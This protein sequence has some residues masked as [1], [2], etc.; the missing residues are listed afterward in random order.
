MTRPEPP[1][2]DG[3]NAVAIRLPSGGFATIADYL[4]ARFGQAPTEAAITRG[5]V[6]DDEL[7][8]VDLSTPFTPGRTTW[9]YRTPPEEAPVPFGIDIL[10]RDDD[11]IVVDKPHFLATMPRGRH[12][13]ESVVVRLR[14]KTGLE[15]CSPAHR[16]DRLTAGVLVC[17][18]RPEVRGVYQ[19]LFASR[20]VVKTYEA[21]AAASNLEFPQTVRSRIIKERGVLTAAEVP[22]EPNS[23]TV[24]ALLE[25]RDG[26]GRYECRPLT[27]KTHQI[28]VHLNSLG[29]PILGDPL[30]PEV[31]PDAPAD[32]SKPLRLLAKSIAFTDPL[33][34]ARREFESN[35]QLDWPDQTKSK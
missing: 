18:V 23:E 12:V 4:G 15:Q 24:I 30:Y 20:A 26:L 22:G 1:L 32:F 13:T 3:L 2:R 33:T 27:G 34:G 29:I 21:I 7:R 17:T 10:H 14:R 35:R 5:D 8:P 19:E 6:F 25:T 16:L 11:L 28:R 9:L 31:L